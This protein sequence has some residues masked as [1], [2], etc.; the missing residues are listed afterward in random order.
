VFEY[1]LSLRVRAL[2]H[3]GV[4]TF[5]GRSC[6]VPANARTLPRHGT[7]MRDPTTRRVI[8]IDPGSI[9]CGYGVVDRRG[10]TMRHVASGTIKA[11]RGPLVDRLVVIY[12]ALIEVCRTY[13]PTE[14]AI[15]GIFY[16]KNADSALKLGH[17][18]GAA[19]L[20]LGHA[21]LTVAEYE[22]TRVKQL[23]TGVGSAPKVQVKLMVERLLGAVSTQSFDESDA[24]A[25]AICHA[26]QRPLSRSAAS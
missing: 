26:H 19:I 13:A 8:G 7:D 18:R 12:D 23:V 20:A 16:Q 5:D 6:D 2:P 3:D 24:L 4:A 1:S 17:A 25:I 22:P 14:G 21:G 9:R 15:E 10:S 11:G